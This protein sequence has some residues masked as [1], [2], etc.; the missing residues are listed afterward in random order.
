PPS[1]VKRPPQELKGYARVSLA[2]GE[3]KVVTMALEP[4][5]FAYWDDGAKKW[6]IDGGSYEVLI[7]ASSRDIR[8]RNAI[9]VSARVLSP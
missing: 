7:G 3:R 5:A 9:D 4:R 1:S 8:L 2:P 6:A